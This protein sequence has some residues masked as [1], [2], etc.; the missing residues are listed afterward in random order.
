[1][2]LKMQPKVTKIIGN[3][4][5]VILSGTLLKLNYEMALNTDFQFSSI[6]FIFLS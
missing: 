6:H 3:V 4:I 2:Y 5:S 1:M